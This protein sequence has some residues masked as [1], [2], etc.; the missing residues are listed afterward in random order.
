MRIDHEVDIYQTVK[1]IR[2]NRPHF[3]ENFVSTQLSKKKEKVSHN[4]SGGWRP[5]V[6]WAQL[7]KDGAHPSPFTALAFPN[8]KKVPNPCWVDR[9]GFP[10]LAW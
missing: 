1:Q 2:I 8:S 7:M 5:T 3:V 9:E 4:S 6:S 10:V